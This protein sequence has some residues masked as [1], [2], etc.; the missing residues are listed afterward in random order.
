MNQIMMG[1]LRAVAWVVALVWLLL[2]AFHIWGAF[3]VYVWFLNGIS[4][5]GFIASLFVVVT[6]TPYII[7]A[8][9]RGPINVST[10]AIVDWATL[11]YLGA[12]VFG[13]RLFLTVTEGTPVPTSDGRAWLGIFIW[14]LLAFKVGL[15]ADIWIRALRRGPNPLDDVS[16]HVK[17]PAS[18]IDET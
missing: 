8:R 7:R 14:A 4:V 6:W 5:F 2:I 10:R 9:H 13:T 12:I 1:L 18:I 15:R 17:G 3:L 16:D 11:A